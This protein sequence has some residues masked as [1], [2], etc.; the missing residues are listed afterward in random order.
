MGNLIWNPMFILFLF[1]EELSPSMGLRYPVNCG[2][3]RP[4]DCSE[5]LSSRWRHG[6]SGFQLLV[7]GVELPSFVKTFP[8]KRLPFSHHG[9]RF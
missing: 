5:T 6:T 7:S 8:G 3:W 4:L 9:V 1:G 2:V